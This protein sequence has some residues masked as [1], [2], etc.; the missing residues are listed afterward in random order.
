MTPSVFLLHSLTSSQQKIKSRSE[1]KRIFILNAFIPHEL[2]PRYDTSL[3]PHDDNNNGTSSHHFPSHLHPEHSIFAYFAV[4]HAVAPTN[5]YVLLLP[6]YVVMLCQYWMPKVHAE[7]FFSLFRSF[8][9]TLSLNLNKKL[10]FTRRQ[11]KFFFIFYESRKSFN[12]YS[13]LIHYIIDSW[14]FFS[15]VY[16]IN[17]KYYFLGVNFLGGIFKKNLITVCIVS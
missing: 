7:I 15:L 10:I 3:T 12:W 5:F 1:K 13:I 6:S 9:T 8:F 4:K 11:A 17:T 2:L 14:L 16:V